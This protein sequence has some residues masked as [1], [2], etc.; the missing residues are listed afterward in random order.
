[1]T[2]LSMLGG[3]FL[4][5]A[6]SGLG[7]LVVL[8]G[9]LQFVLLWGLWTVRSWAWTWSMVLYG[10]NLVLQ[11]LNLAVGNVEYVLAIP[12]TGAIV[13]YLYSKRSLYRESR[14]TAAATS[15]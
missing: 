7:L 14:S 11:V 12:V 2:L 4:I 1:M 10:L 3:F 6:G 9:G 13:W 8:L 15:V 5:V